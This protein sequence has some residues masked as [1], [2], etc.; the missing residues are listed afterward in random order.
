MRIE[1]CHCCFVVV[2]LQLLAFAFEGHGHRNGCDLQAFPI[3]LH[4]SAFL[5]TLIEKFLRG[6][7][8]EMVEREKVERL[9]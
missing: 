8:T 6:N 3:V 7:I 5:S 4:S 9:T 2:E 1:K